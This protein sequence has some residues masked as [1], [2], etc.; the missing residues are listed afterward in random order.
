[1]RNCVVCQGAKSGNPIKAPLHPIEPELNPFDQ[2]HVDIL[3]PLPQSGK[4]KYLIMCVDSYIE[5]YKSIF[6]HLEFKYCAYSVR[7]HFIAG[8]STLVTSTL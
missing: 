3:G 6:I 7:D 8:H 1:M 5:T 4:Y 2:I